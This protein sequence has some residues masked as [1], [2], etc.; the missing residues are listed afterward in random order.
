METV[1]LFGVM[2]PLGSSSG[3]VDHDA[4]IRWCA[5]GTHQ[6]A[7]ERHPHID[8]PFWASMTFT[9][10]IRLIRAGLAH[11]PIKHLNAIKSIDRLKFTNYQHERNFK[12]TT[13]KRVRKFS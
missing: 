4:I 7:C 11:L 3:K 9:A 6:R 13:K 1:T 5:V 8:A 12:V 2:I 10:V